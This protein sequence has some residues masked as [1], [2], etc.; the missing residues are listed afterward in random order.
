MIN[1]LTGG[2]LKNLRDSNRLWSS[3]IKP[4]II[5]VMPA[6]N[7]EKTVRNTYNDLPKDLIEE[8]ILVDDVSRDKTVEKAKKLGITVYIHKQNKGYGGT[9][10]PVM[11]R[12]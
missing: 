11:I 2:C 3:K 4:K 10:K 5:V 9:K 8:V 7:A 1:C 6:Y 12:P